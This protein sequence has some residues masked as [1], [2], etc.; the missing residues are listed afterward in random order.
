LVS[1]FYARAL[2]TPDLI[3]FDMGGTTAKICLVQDGNPSLAREFEAARVRR[4]QK[5]SGLTLKIPAVEMIEI[6]AGGGSIG[7]LDRLGVKPFCLMDDPEVA[8]AAVRQG[9]TRAAAAMAS[10]SGSSQISTRAPM[11]PASCSIA[12]GRRC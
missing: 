1:G 12:R 11:S 2:G 3:S 4:F 7:R 5:G 9:T 8:K 10:R 6:G